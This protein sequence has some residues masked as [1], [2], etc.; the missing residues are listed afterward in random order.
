[1]RDEDQSIEKYTNLWRLPVRAADPVCEDPRTH[2]AHPRAT[3]TTQR[4]EHQ[5]TLSD[6]HPQVR[7]TGIDDEPR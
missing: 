5:E 2:N 6:L 7:R 1:V 4:V 3:Q